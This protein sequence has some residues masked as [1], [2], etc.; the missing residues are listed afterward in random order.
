MPKAKCTLNNRIL[1][2]KRKD[3]MYQAVL[4]DLALIRVIEK[5]TAEMLLGYEIPD[6]L[7]PPKKIGE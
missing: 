3:Q 1:E 4:I 5:E 6:Y 2:N 7:T